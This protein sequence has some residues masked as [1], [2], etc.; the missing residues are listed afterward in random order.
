MATEKVLMQHY[1]FN[2]LFYRYNFQFFINP[3][4]M[5]IE[6]VSMYDPRVKVVNI[7]GLQVALGEKKIVNFR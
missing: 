2:Y 1:H 3:F 4:F 6:W 7:F 5:M